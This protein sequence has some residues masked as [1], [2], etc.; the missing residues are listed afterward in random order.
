MRFQF[1]FAAEP[2]ASGIGFDFG[3][4]QRHPLQ[5]DQPLG[6]QHAQHLHEQIIQSCLVP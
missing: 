3:S 2:V 1:L 6:A 5:R 4:V